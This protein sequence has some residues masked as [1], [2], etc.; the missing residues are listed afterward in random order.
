MQLSQYDVGRFVQLLLRSHRVFSFLLE[1]FNH[2]TE[3]LPCYLERTLSYFV[4]HSS[5]VQVFFDPRRGIAGKG[6]ARSAFRHG[7]P[8]VA[9]AGSRPRRPEEDENGKREGEMAKRRRRHCV[10][11]YNRDEYEE[12]SRFMKQFRGVCEN[13]KRGVS[14]FLL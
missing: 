10:A 7:G 6:D 5:F 13:K 4:Y 14:T 1:L 3:A 8:H 9:T 2:L 11:S 12:L